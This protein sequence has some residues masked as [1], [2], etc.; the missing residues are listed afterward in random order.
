M[1]WKLWSQYWNITKFWQVGATNDQTETG[2]TCKFV[3]ISSTSTRLKGDSFLEHIITVNKTWCHYCKL[4]SKLWHVNYPLKKK[5][6][7]Q[8]SVGKVICTVFC[9]MKGGDPSGFPGTRTNH[10]C[11]LSWRL[12][13]PESGQRRRQPFSW[14]TITPG[15]I[16]IWR[17]CSTLPVLAG[18]CYHIQKTDKIWHLLTSIYSGQWK[19]DCMDNIFLATVPSPHLWISGSPPLI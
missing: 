6:K 19:M 1:H 7:T 4:E 12:K 14:N 15:P 2:W 16:P 13:L 17:Q 18:L 8:P 5:F 3:R 11:W 9:D 10:Q